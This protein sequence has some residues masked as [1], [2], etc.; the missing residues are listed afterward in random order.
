M[1]DDAIKGCSHGKPFSERCIGCELVS[2]REGERW[3]SENL[4]RYRNT[5]ARL[6]AEQES[7]IGRQ[8]K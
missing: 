3:A 7:L 5:I 1:G 4:A 2:A 8:F 6:T